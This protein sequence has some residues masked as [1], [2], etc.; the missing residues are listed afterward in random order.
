[1]STHYIDLNIE[2]DVIKFKN[3]LS[4]TNSD[5]IFLKHPLIPED[6]FEKH[7]SQPVKI[8]KSNK[9]KNIFKKD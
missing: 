5:E 9:F 3:L 4:E 6:L 2:S 1:M 8:D 7:F